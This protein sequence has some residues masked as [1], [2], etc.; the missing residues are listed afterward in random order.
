MQL[1]GLRLDQEEKEGRREQVRSPPRAY[2]YL[3]SQQRV[4]GTFSRAVE[5]AGQW[6]PPLGLTW[7]GCVEKDSEVVSKLS[8]QQCCVEKDLELHPTSVG[9][10]AGVD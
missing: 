9:K 8:V 4:G 1:R 10:G 6:F 2:K 3:E 5:W 7:E